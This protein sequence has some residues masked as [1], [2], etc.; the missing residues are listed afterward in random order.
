MFIEERGTTCRDD[1]RVLHQ[2]D[3]QGAVESHN[4]YS[5]GAPASMYWRQGGIDHEHPEELVEQKYHDQ[6]NG[7]MYPVVRVLRDVAAN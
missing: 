4:H 5:K 7:D 1:T 2:N 3:V 6:Q